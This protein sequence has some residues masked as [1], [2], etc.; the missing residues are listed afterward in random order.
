MLNGELDQLCLSSCSAPIAFLQIE[1]VQAA[2]LFATSSC[3]NSRDDSVCFGIQPTC[4]I[5][6]GS[7][8]KACISNVY[9]YQPELVLM[10]ACIPGSG[11]NV[12]ETVSEANESSVVSPPFQATLPNTQKTNKS[13]RRNHAFDVLQQNCKARTQASFDAD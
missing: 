9:W 2:C 7:V 11:Y 8:I 1:N 3:A 12:Q 6:W 10:I 4:V 5:F 13:T